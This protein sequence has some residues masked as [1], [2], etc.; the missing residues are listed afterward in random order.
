M[1]KY[2]HTILTVATAL[3]LILS[4]VGCKASET[5]METQKPATPPRELETVIFGSS[6]NDT[7]F[8]NAGSTKFDSKVYKENVAN[9][10]ITVDILGTKYTGVYEETAKLP[11]SDVTVFNYSIK[12]TESGR[13]LVDSNTGDVLEYIGIPCTQELITEKDYVDFINAVLQG[14][15]YLNQY[16]YKCTTHYYTFAEKEIRSQVVDGFR[17]CGENEK[18]GT[19]SFYYTKSIEG[20][21]LPNHISAEFFNGMFS[22]EIYEYDYTA[23]DFSSIISRIGEVE[24]SID[25]HL[26]DNVKD[27]CSII[28]IEHKNKSVLVQNGVAYI[29][30]TSDVTYKSAY[31]NEPVSI[32]VQTIT[33]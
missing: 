20:I 32:F 28:S 8:Y 31:Y 9:P 30:I 1:K 18:I 14:R 12:D 33:G 13:I 24:T 15:S 29:A 5:D 27:G 3:L 10:T 19:R 16:D 6:E 23:E 2:K 17:I 21:K 4:L 11:K 7:I 26:K 22:L 25:K